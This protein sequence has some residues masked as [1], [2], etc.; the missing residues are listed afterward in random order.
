MIYSVVLV[1]VANRRTIASSDYWNKGV[2]RARLNKY[3]SSLA[4]MA[5]KSER[6]K[7]KPAVISGLKFFSRES[8]TIV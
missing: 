1:N 3:L 7:Y 2:S 6:L 8:E 5:E 4:E